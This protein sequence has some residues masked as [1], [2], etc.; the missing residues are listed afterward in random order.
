LV[1]KLWETRQVNRVQLLQ[2]HIFVLA[3]VFSGIK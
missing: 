1:A 3:C 2:E